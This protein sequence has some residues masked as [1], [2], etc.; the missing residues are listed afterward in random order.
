M[1]QLGAAG[2]GRPHQ[3]LLAC[4]RSVNPLSRRA[5]S[6]APPLGPPGRGLDEHWDGA[7]QVAASYF[8]PLRISDSRRSATPGACSDCSWTTRTVAWIEPMVLSNGIG[9]RR[10]M[11]A[12]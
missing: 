11:S 3:Q 5:G 6:I 8:G 12:H 9:C 2:P 10:G 1:R 7:V 4:W